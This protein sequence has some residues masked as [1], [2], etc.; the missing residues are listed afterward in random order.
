MGV[1]SPAP[2]HRAQTNL[3][4]APLVR[5]LNNENASIP[6]KD[7][8]KA[9]SHMPIKQSGTQTADLTA[10]FKGTCSAK[11]DPRP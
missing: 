4:H 2:V 3:T 9:Y 6:S 5:G 11:I 10:T 1:G 8:Q 7:F